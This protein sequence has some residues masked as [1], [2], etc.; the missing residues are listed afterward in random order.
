MKANAQLGEMHDRLIDFH[1]QNPKE[2][3]CDALL[4]LVEDPLKPRDEHGRFRVNP[5]LLLLAIVFALAFGIFL[6]FSMVQS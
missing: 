2:R 3:F 5:I 4:R 1:L 6:V